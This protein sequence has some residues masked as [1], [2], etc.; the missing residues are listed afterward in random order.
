MSERVRKVV[1]GLSIVTFLGCLGYT[2]YDEISDRLAKKHFDDVLKKA[3][4]S[5]EIQVAGYPDDFV[6]DPRIMEIYKQNK[7][8]VGWIKIEGTTLDYPVFQ[9]KDDVNRTPKDFFY[10]RHGIDK[11]Y[12]VLGLPFVDY[13]V[14]LKKSSKHVVICGHNMGASDD[15]FGVLK[16]YNKHDRYCGN[17]PEKA[18]EFYKE[19]PVIEFDSVY[20]SNKYKIFAIFLMNGAVKG[21]KDNKKPDFDYT[22]FADA[23][24]DFNEFINQAKNRSLLNFGVDVNTGDSFLTLSTCSYELDDFRLAVVA[25]KIRENEDL[26]AA[27]VENNK[28]PLMPKCF[29]DEFGGVAPEFV[30][31]DYRPATAAKAAAAVDKK[32]GFKRP[33]DEYV[34][35][36]GSKKHR[37]PFKV[38]CDMVENEVG[39]DFPEEAVKAQAI[40]SHSKLLFNNKK[41]DVP[42]VG[43][44]PAS[45][46]TKEIVKKVMNKGIFYHNEIAETTCFD[47]SAGRTNSSKDVWGFESPYLVSVVSRYD[48]EAPR[49]EQANV[50]SCKEL[51]KRFKDG[52]DLDLEEN[53]IK[54]RKW[55]KTLTRTDGGYNHEMIVAGHTECFSPSRGRKVP[56][57]GHL[58]RQYVLPEIGSSKFKVGYSKKRDS[59][60]FISYGYG[61][62]VGLSQWGAKFYAEKKG[63]DYVRIIK[64]YFPGT[65]VRKIY[66]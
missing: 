45:K 23:A 41:G 5:G 58:I 54:P 61:H 3:Q 44:K 59:F 48:K 34:M 62:G 19:H 15:M 17:N 18:I 42:T 16:H 52:L 25:R 28:D 13:K 4:N 57:T 36:N 14:D 27:E 30:T 10:I 24:A 21:G 55:F 9:R 29:Y 64:H 40:T 37:K 1:A 22:A 35:I 43:L 63:W 47:C 49:Y 32:L 53:D 6:K 2:G 26:G 7:D 11:E 38:I 56:I 31:K 60:K 12:A 51:K 33:K 8:V 66:K 65:K 46:R 20:E 39:S 50:F